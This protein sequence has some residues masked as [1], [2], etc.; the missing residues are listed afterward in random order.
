M[1][2]DKAALSK[3]LAE[4]QKAHQEYVAQNGPDYRKYI[5]PPPGSYLEKYRQRKKEIGAV[6]SPELRHWSGAA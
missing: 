2:V 5:N 4:L 3:E 6:L 1:S